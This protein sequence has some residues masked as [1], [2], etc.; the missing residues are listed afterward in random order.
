MTRLTIYTRNWFVNELRKYKETNAFRFEMSQGGTCVFFCS[1]M[2][3]D[4][5]QFV[6]LLENFWSKE[7][8][9]SS[10]RKMLV[11]TWTSERF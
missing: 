5:V 7:I 10:G 9:T 4:V 1:L 3:C 2:G 8:P 6:S 11:S